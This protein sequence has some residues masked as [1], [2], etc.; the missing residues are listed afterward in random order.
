MGT[1]SSWFGSGGNVRGFL[2]SIWLRKDAEQSSGLPLSPTPQEWAGRGFLLQGCLEV[3]WG[4]GC[5][6][7]V[8]TGAGLCLGQG[9]LEEVDSALP[10]GH[11]GNAI[12]GTDRR[13]DWVRGLTVGKLAIL[14]NAM[15]TPPLPL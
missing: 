9:G 12:R 14:R 3:A 5:W 15:E 2:S 4:V 11:I 10:G 6:P 1:L 13:V 8:A 7:V